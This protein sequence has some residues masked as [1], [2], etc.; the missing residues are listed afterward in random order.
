MSIDL[1]TSKWNI[2]GES[3]LM[4]EL[5]DLQKFMFSDRYHLTG[6]ALTRVC[7]SMTGLVLWITTFNCCRKSLLLVV[8][9]VFLKARG[10]YFKAE[11][12]ASGPLECSACSAA[13]PP[14]CT[15]YTINFVGVEGPFSDEVSPSTAV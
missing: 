7:P 1:N 15:S 9:N 12:L 8:L 4:P 10:V 2:T 13:G 6:S 5:A 11:S 3:V 14:N